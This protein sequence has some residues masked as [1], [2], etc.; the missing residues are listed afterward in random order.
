M[1]K[2]KLIRI[3]TVPESL[4]LFRGQPKYMSSFF[5]VICISS[6]GDSIRK[7]KIISFIVIIICSYLVLLSGSR[8]SLVGIFVLAIILFISEGFKFNV[9]SFLF[10]LFVLVIS[11]NFLFTSNWFNK[12]METIIQR[13]ETKTTTFE[14]EWEI[15]GYD[16]IYLYPEYL[17]VGAGEM[18]NKRFTKAYHQLEMHT[19]FGTI[20]FSYGILGFFFFIKFLHQIIKQKYLMNLLIM[21]PVLLYNLTHQG[22]RFTQFWIFLALVLIFSYQEIKQK[23]KNYVRT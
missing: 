16:R 23:S 4:G 13:N 19:A 2:P 9:K 10:T 15:R 14:S 17:L 11:F 20:L 8:A 6:P 1:P 22:L 5:E 21:S 3:T 7:N 18:A 12:Q